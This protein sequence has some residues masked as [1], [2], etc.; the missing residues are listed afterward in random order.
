VW[1]AVQAVMRAVW[2]ERHRPASSADC[3]PSIGVLP[4]DVLDIVFGLVAISI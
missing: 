3:P 2:I 1:R 4:D